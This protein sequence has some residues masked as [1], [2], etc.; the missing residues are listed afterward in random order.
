MSAPECASALSAVIPRYLRLKLALGRRYAIEQR[1]LERLGAF[2]QTR[3][4]STRDLTPDTFTAWGQTLQHL[5]PTLRRNHLRI[6][7]NLCLYRRV[8]A[9]AIATAPSARGRHRPGSWCP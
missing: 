5:T 8:I 1:V 7:R 3:T 4:G 2:V 9:V 6:V